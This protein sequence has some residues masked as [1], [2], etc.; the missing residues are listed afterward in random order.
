MMPT[1]RLAAVDDEPLALRR[2]RVILDEIP[3]VELVGSAQ[4]CAE[5]EQMIADV[6]PDLLLLDI[7][8]RDGTGFDILENCPAPNRPQVIF[9]TAFD[10]YA[11]KAFEHSA[12][13]YL[14]KPIEPARLQEALTRA[15]K[16]TAEDGGE[17]RVNEMLE[18]I[19]NLRSALRDQPSDNEDDDFWIRSANGSFTR[20]SLRDVD[21]IGS[22]DDYVRLHA[23]TSSHL[24][25]SSIRAI[26][27]KLDA[28][29]FVRVHRSALVR[30]SAIVE[31][32]RSATGRREIVLH[33]GTR[34]PTGRVH[35]SALRDILRRN[36][37]LPDE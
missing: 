24:L 32:K 21:W 17:A 16:R 25:R 20:V 22:E 18:V 4:S 28:E 35:Y 34:I 33:D 13:D 30:L 9:V 2:L 3:H 19:A 29:Q 1:I 10:H 7:R 11:V 31:V 37:L 15:R 6:S 14:L 5:A 36:D 26:E 12:V 23:G 27:P 8:M